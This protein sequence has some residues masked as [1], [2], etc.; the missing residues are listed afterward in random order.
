MASSYPTSSLLTNRLVVENLKHRPVRTLLSIVA[1]AVQVTMVLTLVGLSRGVLEDQQRRSRGI[2]ADIIVRPPAGSA[3]ALTTNFDKGSH[4]VAFVA[5]QPHVAAVTGVLL[6]STGLL[7]SVTGI[8]LPSFK[9]LTGGF[10]Y[11]AGGPFQNPRDVIIDEYYASQHGLHVGD[12][13]SILNV[14][15]H[16]CAII[17]PG[18]LARIFV[19]LDELQRLTANTDKLTIIYVKLDNPANINVVLADLR[20]KMKQ[21][22]IIPMEEF[23]SQFSVNSVPM[24]REFI[25]VVI[26]LGV[27]VGFLVVFLSMY[28][29][30]LERTR[31]IG[32]LKALGASPAYVVRILLTETLVLA[33]VGSA[34]GIVFTYGTRWVINT[35]VPGSLLEAIVPD[36]WPIAAGIAIGGAMLGAF[37]PG[38]KAARQNA[39]EALAYE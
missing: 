2:G 24:L 33:I 27:L 30:V 1:I 36:W 9:H 7:T 8:D 32:I 39:I 11:L 13:M 18:M 22:Q 4:F 21:Y 10:H 34:L 5:K 16:V 15:W 3:I 14:N 12:T 25:A 37:Y 19:R 23:L 26:G 29:A 6:Q 20:K 17:Q 31:E 35:F 28:T 38:W